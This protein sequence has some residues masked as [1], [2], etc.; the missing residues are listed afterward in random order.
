MDSTGQRVASLE[1]TLGRASERI[2]ELR[3]DGDD[4]GA[5]ELEATVNQA[6]ALI[7]ASVF[8]PYGRVAELPSLN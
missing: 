2:V 1:D 6:R 3:D 5:A 7:V 4:E 8:A